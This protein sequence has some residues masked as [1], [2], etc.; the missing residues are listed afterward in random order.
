MWY[1]NLLIGPF[2]FDLKL[3][4]LGLTKFVEQPVH[5]A[6]FALP[7]SEMAE[8]GFGAA[9]AGSRAST[10]PTSGSRTSEQIEALIADAP[11]PKQADGRAGGSGRRGRVTVA[12]AAG[13][14]RG[15]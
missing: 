6:K 3:G 15:R 10:S 14:P 12:G 13:T 4:N 7:S 11:D 8:D 2:A 9:P 5:L 1:L